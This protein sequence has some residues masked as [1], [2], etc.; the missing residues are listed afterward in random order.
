MDIWKQQSICFVKAKRSTLFKCHLPA[1]TCKSTTPTHQPP[2]LSIT[3]HKLRP[4]PATQLPTVLQ[5]TLAH[6]T[7]SH[8]QLRS[9]LS[10]TI[11]NLHLVTLASFPFTGFG[12]GEACFLVL[13]SS[14]LGLVVP[15]YGCCYCYCCFLPPLFYWFG[16]YLPSN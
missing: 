10:L 5:T 3:I 8:T 1:A 9:A 12:D 14:G 6:Q 2:I 16:N 7:T 4:L 15:F 11:F 13:M